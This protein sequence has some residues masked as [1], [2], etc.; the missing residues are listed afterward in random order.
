V[1]TDRQRVELALL[2]MMMLGVLIAGVNDREHADA[3]ACQALLIEA[4]EE[5]LKLAVKTAEKAGPFE[6]MLTISTSH[7]SQ[8]TAK[9]LEWED[10]HVT[11]FEHGDYGWLIYV[12]PEGHDWA[13]TGVPPDLTLLMLHAHQCGCCWL[14][15]DSDGAV[16]PEVPT[17]DW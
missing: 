12:N 11:Q 5:A 4:T 10:A 15:L 14:L 17:F 9:K 3:K 7:V 16:L 2:P 6:S 1:I 13:G 8:E